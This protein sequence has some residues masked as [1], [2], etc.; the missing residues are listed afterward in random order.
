MKTYE[1]FLVEMAGGNVNPH[2]ARELELHIDNTYHL[3]GREGNQ[4]DAIIKNIHRRMKKG[5]YD[6]SLA[7]K[8][9]GY[10][11]DSGAASYAKIHGNGGSGKDIFNK[12]TRDYLA[13]RYADN[14]LKNIKNG[15]YDHLK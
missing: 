8:L 15:E 10:L 4:K 13:Q 3:S 11:V 9:W 12:P 1:Q 14:E 5:T 6:H 7:P 2:D